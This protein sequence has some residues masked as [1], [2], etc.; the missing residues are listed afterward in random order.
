VNLRSF[1]SKLL[2]KIPDFDPA[3]MIQ[4]A[5]RWVWMDWDDTII[6]WRVEHFGQLR[7]YERS[8]LNSKRIIEKIHAAGKKVMLFSCRFNH[9]QPPAQRAA[10][11]AQVY[12]DIK[13]FNL[14]IDAIW[15]YDKPVCCCGL[16]NGIW[17]GDDDGV[18]AMLDSLK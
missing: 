4:E 11:V 7:I 5:G 18:E 16:D 17:R 14:K 1:F 3:L 8:G 15:P 6:D 13:R 9:D 12:A 2:R 10:A